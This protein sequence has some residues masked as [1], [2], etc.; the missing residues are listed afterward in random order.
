MKKNNIVKGLLAT[1][2]SSA[3]IIGGAIVYSDAKELLN[4]SS[5]SELKNNYSKNS[6]SKNIN[7]SNSRSGETNFEYDFLVSGGTSSALV[8]TIGGVQMMRMG[9]RKIWR[10]KKQEG[11]GWGG[12]EGV[13]KS[14]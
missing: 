2:L 3:L 12:K 11:K 7:Q 5:F 9:S 4:S 10:E 13:G 1:A 8:A 6:K 14:G